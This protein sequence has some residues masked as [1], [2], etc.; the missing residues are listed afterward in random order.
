VSPDAGKEESMPKK[1]ETTP[2]RERNPQPQGDDLGMPH[3]DR[4]RNPGRR[5][6]REESDEEVE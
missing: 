4:Q 3:D 2:T 1:N 5:P 6:E